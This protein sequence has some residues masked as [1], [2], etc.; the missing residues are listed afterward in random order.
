MAWHYGALANGIVAIAYFMIVYA[1]LHPLVVG[2]DWRRNRLGL[3]TAAIFFT[4]AVH[5]GEHLLHLVGPTLGLGGDHNRSFRAA[6]AW[7]QTA[8]DVLTAAVGVYYWTLRKSYGAVMQ[9]AA[10]FSDLKERE[11]QALQ[12]NDDI[13]QRLTVAKMAME[14]DRHD[15]SQEALEDAL[16]AASGIISGLL[17]D[18]STRTVQPGDLVRDT[19]GA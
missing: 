8:W 10:L 17:G 11:R 12:I 13:V 14:L 1:I 18:A 9:G 15:M 2:G 6:W 16:R 7:H 4:C 3:A 5:H 19:Q